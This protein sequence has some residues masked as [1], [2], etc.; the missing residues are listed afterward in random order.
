MKKKIRKSGVLTTKHKTLGKFIKRRV[1][2]S[3]K[4]TAGATVFLAGSFNGWSEHS[5]PMKDKNGDGLFTTF[6]F[7]MPGRYEYKFIINGTWIM[8]TEN[9][10]FVANDKNSMNSV[11]IVE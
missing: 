6:C 3:V 7:L 8:D 9:P 10:N 2:F 4:A 5:K 11:I 1:C